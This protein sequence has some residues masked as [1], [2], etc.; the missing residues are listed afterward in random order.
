MGIQL[1]INS[2]F[3]FCFVSVVVIFL[4]IYMERV[5]GLWS[6]KLIVNKSHPCCP[7][8]R[9]LTYIRND[10]HL[11]KI[12]ILK[13]ISFSICEKATYLKTDFFSIKT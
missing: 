9:S 12:K 6:K 1:H 7:A 8:F 10:V 13:P 3:V 11:C 5:S 2:H 4:K